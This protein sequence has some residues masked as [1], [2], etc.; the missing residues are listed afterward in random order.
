[1]K[2]GMSAYDPKRTYR[3]R[4]GARTFANSGVSG[5]HTNKKT[6]EVGIWEGSRRNAIPIATSVTLI[7]CATQA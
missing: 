2:P 1:M 4:V 6:A 7:T 5:G 3:Q